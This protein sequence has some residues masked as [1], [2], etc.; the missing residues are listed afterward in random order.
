MEH[1]SPFLISALGG[2]SVRSWSLTFIQ[3]DK[4]DG[5]ARDPAR[6]LPP[7]SQEHLAQRYRSPSAG[8]CI[9]PM[10]VVPPCATLIAS[11]RA[12]EGLMMQLKKTHCTSGGPSSRC[13]ALRTRYSLRASETSRPH[14]SSRPPA[15]APTASLVSSFNQHCSSP[16]SASSI[17]AS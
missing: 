4:R 9:H 11:R 17:A 12:A 7:H 10:G 14:R 3:I 15:H 6:H 2:L 13:T 1:Q 8:G 16:R 5:L